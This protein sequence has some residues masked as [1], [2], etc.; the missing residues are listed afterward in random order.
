MRP[1]GSHTV[2]ARVAAVMAVA[3]LATTT[4]SMGARSA[5]GVGAQSPP[6]VGGLSVVGSNA[7]WSLI[8]PSEFTDTGDLSPESLV[9]VD[10][11][12]HYGITKGVSSTAY[13]P[14]THVDASADG[15][16]L[17]AHT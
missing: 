12:V 8:Q 2:S 3:T 17:A 7:C 1:S 5:A 15:P 16:L 9:A 13:G 14:Y 10:C 6:S 11:L 4:A